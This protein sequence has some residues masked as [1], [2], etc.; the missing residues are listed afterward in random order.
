VKSRAKADI[1]F[2]PLLLNLNGRK[3]LVVGAGTVAAGKIDGLLSHGAK[4]TVVSPRAIPAI[5]AQARAGVLT[6]LRREFSPED[7]RGA[8]LVIAAT[9][10]SEVNGSVF[11]ACRAQHVLCN[12]VDDPQH[13]DFFYPAVVR[14][15]ALQ[16]AISTNGNLPALASRL[17]K[18][19]DQQFGREWAPWVEHVGKLRREIL[20]R[21]TS[22]QKRRELLLQLATPEAFQA[23]IRSH[24]KPK[25][26]KSN[27]PKRRSKQ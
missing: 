11:R 10:S 19:L 9:N 4:I 22:A 5:Q 14:R 6:L 1:P 3:C 26:R 23:F 20:A 27:A 7:V 2:F 16:I 25:S 24:A 8:F 15:G 18:E 12:A 21:K 13:C 17:R